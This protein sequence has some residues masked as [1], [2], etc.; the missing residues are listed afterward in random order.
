MIDNRYL[1]MGGVKQ[2]G[3]DFSSDDINPS[4]H[5]CGRLLA[6]VVLKVAFVVSILFLLGAC[7]KAELIPSDEYNSRGSEESNDSTKVTPDFDVN[8]WEGAIDAGFEFGGERT[9]VLIKK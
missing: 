2:A 4:T 1:Q 9:S 6:R 5:T 8:G 3:L 7:Q